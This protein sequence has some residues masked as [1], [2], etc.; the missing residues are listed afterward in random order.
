[1]VSRIQ[2]R[3]IRKVRTIYF[4]NFH[5]KEIFEIEIVDYKYSLSF[6]EVNIVLNDLTFLAD[7][8]GKTDNY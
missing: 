1:M 5:Y 8:I 3:V 4:K 6:N 2:R 7:I